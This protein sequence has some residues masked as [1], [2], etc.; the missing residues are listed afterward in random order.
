[1]VLSGGEWRDARPA[2]LKV[3]PPPDEPTLHRQWT[4]VIFKKSFYGI[5]AMALR[6]IGAEL[7]H[8]PPLSNIRKGSVSQGVAESF[9]AVLLCAF[10]PILIV[11]C[12]SGTPPKIAEQPDVIVTLDGNRHSCI[13]ALE[14]EP[15]GSSVPCKEAA[16]F[17]KD[18][19]RAPGGSIYD[20]RIV[21]NVD[22]T[23][24]AS[25]RDALNDAGYRFIGGRK[26]P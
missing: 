2:L 20:I 11:G 17:V 21:A 8:G 10:T 5:H 25:V 15:Q 24:I 23:Q 13:V 16:S 7:A 4:P 6:T 22:D 18:Q 9:R 1:M 26:L 3:T 14:K 12:G 19:L